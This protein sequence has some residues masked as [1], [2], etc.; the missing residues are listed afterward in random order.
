MH[1]DGLALSQTVLD[2][3]ADKWTHLVICAPGSDSVTPK[4]LT[5]TLRVLERD[6]LVERKNMIHNGAWLGRPFATRPTMA[7]GATRHS[8]LDRRSR[9]RRLP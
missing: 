8:A 1:S 3:L 6:G 5:Q 9:Q 7:Y 4:I 2:V